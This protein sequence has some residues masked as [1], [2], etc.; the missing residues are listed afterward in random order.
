MSFLLSRMTKEDTEMDETREK[1]YRMSRTIQH[2]TTPTPITPEEHSK[3]TMSYL[4]TKSREKSPERVDETREKFLRM[5]QLQTVSSVDPNKKVDILSKQ[6]EEDVNSFIYRVLNDEVSIG[7]K[8]DDLY[9]YLETEVKDLG[10][11]LVSNRGVLLRNIAISAI[12]SGVVIGV[13]SSTIG[14]TVALPTGL[15]AMYVLGRTFGL[16]KALVKRMGLVVSKSQYVTKKRLK[17][18]PIPYYVKETFKKLKIDPKYYDFTYG[19]IM[20]RMML[21]GVRFMTFKTWYAY[22]LSATLPGV[23]YKTASEVKKHSKDVLGEL[24]HWMSLKGLEDMSDIVVNPEGLGDEDD[25]KKRNPSYLFND[26]VHEIQTSPN[27]DPQLSNL[28]DIMDKGRSKMIDLQSG[29]RIK[30]AAALGTTLAVGLFSGQIGP[31]VIQMVIQNDLVQGLALNSLIQSSSFDQYIIQLGLNF[32][33]EITDKIGH[34]RQKIMTQK[35]PKDSSWTKEFFALLLGERLLSKET[36]MT[37]TKEQ[38]LM[39]IEERGILYEKHPHATSPSK[40]ELVKCIHHHQTKIF[41]ITHQQLVLNMMKYSLEAATMGILANSLVNVYECM[42]IPTL[43]EAIG[44]L[45]GSTITKETIDK[46]KGYFK[47]HPEM[48]FV[49]GPED[50]EVEVIPITRTDNREFIYKVREEQIELRAATAYS[51]QRIQQY[52]TKYHIDPSLVD[53][54]VNLS[55]LQD[56]ITK[57]NVETQS[58]LQVDHVAQYGSVKNEDLIPSHLADEFKD[59]SFTDLY[60]SI[61]RSMASSTVESQMPLLG[62]LLSSVNRGV[63]VINY[64]K[65][66]YNIALAFGKL[67]DLVQQ[68]TNTWSQSLPYA[69]LVNLEHLSTLGDSLVDLVVQEPLMNKNVYDVFLTG[70]TNQLKT[71]NI[72]LQELAKDITGQLIG[73]DQIQTDY[74]LLVQNTFLKYTPLGS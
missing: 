24:R 3:N 36:L 6:P 55:Q 42:Y 32:T 30:T 17:K 29:H 47:T 37:L 44:I 61:K 53:G 62:P 22:V 41:E 68:N 8:D 28:G 49:L 74:G 69:P 5:S 14:L 54:L 63:D 7:L 15:E 72:D 66:T 59:L 51:Q 12:T 46:I 60:T 9:G 20:D 39:V 65:N 23:I 73:I 21:E 40:D 67:N 11:H 1:F 70:L 64:S 52:A 48:R 45:P 10:H 33:Q 26:F 38:L 34:L 18:V 27:V 31:D 16:D 19:H 50:T 4:I 57:T 43:S 25:E 35:N 2:I 13:A 71:S 56:L 58:I